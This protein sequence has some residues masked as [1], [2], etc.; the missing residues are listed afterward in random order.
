MAVTNLS[1]TQI[2]ANWSQRMGA[3]VTRIKA[4]VEAV[5]NAPGAAAAAASN[6]W[7]QNTQASVTKYKRNTAAV[8]LQSWQQSFVTKGLPRIATGASA[9]QPKVAAFMSQWVPFLQRTVPN[10][11]ARGTFEQNLARSQAM[12]KAAHTFKYQK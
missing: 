7:L 1:P 3:S 8:T 5:K 2:A 10:L 4:G 11:P 12:I 9:A 6:V